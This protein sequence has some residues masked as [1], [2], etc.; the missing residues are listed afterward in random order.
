MVGFVKKRYGSDCFDD[1]DCYVDCDFCPRS[2]FAPSER[3]SFKPCVGRVEGAQSVGNV[4]CATKA[5]GMDD[6]EETL[7]PPT[8]TL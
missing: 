1:F 6:C 4:P 3:E 8:L 7:P 2:P 5:V